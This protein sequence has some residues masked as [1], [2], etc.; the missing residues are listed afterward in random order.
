[1]SSLKSLDSRSALR[2]F[3]KNKIKNVVKPNITSS[4]RE[5][6]IPNNIYDNIH[7]K[8]RN[9]TN[10]KDRIDLKSIINKT[11]KLIPNIFSP[12]DNQTFP[13]G[14]YDSLFSSET[15][16]DV[17]FKAAIICLWIIAMFYLITT[18][19]T[20][21][22]PGKKYEKKTSPVRPIF[23]HIFLCEF[24]YLIYIFLS[25]INVAQNFQLTNSLCLLANYGLYTSCCFE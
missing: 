23:F 20:M 3:W 8:Y 2:S 25:M 19:I 10:N 1:M 14:F 6:L 22:V 11:K 9:V 5:K 21:L 12:N 24:F 18:I 7:E 16:E 15:E 13:K 17:Y 4:I